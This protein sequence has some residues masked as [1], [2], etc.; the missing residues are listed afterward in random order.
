VWDA[1]YGGS[2]WKTSDCGVAKLKKQ[3]IYSRRINWNRRKGC[4]GCEIYNYNDQ[5]HENK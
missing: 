2:D 1:K 3:K 4:L 5:F